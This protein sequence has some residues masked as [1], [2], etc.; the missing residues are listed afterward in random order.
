[1]STKRSYRRISVKKISEEQLKEACLK[2]GGASTSVGLDISK[3]DIVAVVRWSDGQF[4]APWN[5]KN[6]AEIPELIG[7]LKMMSQTCDSL[8]I[9]LEST[10]TYGEAV[11]VA[12]TAAQLE[13]HRISGKACSDYKEIFDGVPSQHDGKDAAII[14]ELT[15]FN[16]GT[17]WPFEQDSEASQERAHQVYRLDAF[18]K[19][20]RQWGGRL[21]ALMARHWPELGRLLSL[22]SWTI[23]QCLILYGCPKRMLADPEAAAN[24]RRWGRSGLSEATIESILE[25]AR[26]TLGVPMG[27]GQIQWVKDV[28]SELYRSQRE[29]DACEKRLEEMLSDDQSLSPMKKILGAA[30][31]SVLL[32]SVGDPKKYSS[33]GAFLK[34]LGLNLK[35]LSSGKRYG[36]LAITK[37]GPS[38]V[39]RY[40]YFWALRCLKEGK[41]I[42]KWY[43]TFKKVGKGCDPNSEHRKMKGVIALMRKLCRSLWYTRQLGLEFDYDK[44]FPGRPLDQPRSRRKRRKAQP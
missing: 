23:L 30:T 42:P 17:A 19:I 12:M 26:S 25:S 31:L 24:L 8:T 10:G 39:R 4:E 38:I 6:P 41:K 36:Q 18:N 43:E 37:R 44:V 33:S 32:V 13:V 34:A 29:A 11:R 16:K 3:E 22:N 27:E 2:H 40:I 28:A 21:E 35:E 1:M 5:V 15:S 7:L 20:A 9:G 14:A